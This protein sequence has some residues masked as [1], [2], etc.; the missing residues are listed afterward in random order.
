MIAALPRISFV[1]HPTEDTC[2][3]I[4]CLFLFLF[5]VQTFFYLVMVFLE[6]TG[7]WKRC[8]LISDVG[9]RIMILS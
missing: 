9:F 5:T 7:S 6:F 3:Y 2:T 4:F 8:L 1:S